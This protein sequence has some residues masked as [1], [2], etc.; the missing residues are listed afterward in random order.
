MNPIESLSAACIDARPFDVD[1]SEGFGETWETVD[2]FGEMDARALAEWIADRGDLPEPWTHDDARR[3]CYD[4]APF[5]PEDEDAEEK[6]EELREYARENAETDDFAPMMNHA[7]PIED[8]DAER[9]QAILAVRSLPVVVVEYQDRPVLAL[10]GGGMDL[11]WEICESYMRLGYLPPVSFAASLPAM[12]D[13]AE[14]APDVSAQ[15]RDLWIL[16]GA[17]ESCRILEERS[18]SRRERVERQ[19]S[20]LSGEAA[21]VLDRLLEAQRD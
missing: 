15:A 7:Y 10:S 17:E 21:A 9:M 16:Q 18:R 2:P 5:D 13:R 6:T 4:G 1:W 20:A 12:A 8:G 3:L 11:S 19:R 14:K